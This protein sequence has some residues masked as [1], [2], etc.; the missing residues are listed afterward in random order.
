[1]SMCQRCGKDLA[2]HLRLVWFYIVES[3]HD[4]QM[5]HDG[6]AE[7]ARKAIGPGIERVG[8]IEAYR[9]N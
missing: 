7:V 2:T 1:M 5:A 3:D 6:R 9:I 4:K 8:A